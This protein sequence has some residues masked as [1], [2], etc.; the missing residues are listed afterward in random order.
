[1]RIF[2]NSFVEEGDVFGKEGDVLVVFESGWVFD[3]AIVRG[4][5]SWTR[6]VFI[7][8]WRRAGRKEVDG[9]GGLPCGS[10]GKSVL[11][12]STLI[13]QKTTQHNIT[14]HKTS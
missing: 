10:Y 11:M 5:I 7:T 12:S 13:R 8:K 4:M 2:I 9:E 6:Y 3:L 1:L 14:Q